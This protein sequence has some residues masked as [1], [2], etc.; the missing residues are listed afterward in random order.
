M[1]FWHSK[2]LHVAKGG[3]WVHEKITEHFRS[4]LSCALRI[5]IKHPCLTSASWSRDLKSGRDLPRFWFYILFPS[6]NATGQTICE[7]LIKTVFFL[8]KVG[9]HFGDIAQIDLQEEVR[10]IFVECIAPP[11]SPGAKYV[12]IL[13]N[14][15]NIRVKHQFHGWKLVMP[16][17]AATRWLSVSYTHLTLPTIYSV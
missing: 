17:M 11:L 3:P 5:A 12:A 15:M 6:L 9:S 1:H 13:C 4:K 10:G 16:Y 14:I 8:D 2:W 7:I